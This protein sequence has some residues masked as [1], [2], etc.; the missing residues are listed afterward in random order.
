MKSTSLKQRKISLTDKEYMSLCDE[1]KSFNMSF[2]NYSRMILTCRKDRTEIPI[3]KQLASLLPEHINMVNE[4]ITDE[5]T[6][7]KFLQWEEKLWQ[8]I[9]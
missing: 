5:T 1:A 8:A 6:K 3:S 4:L 9:K 2:S 7:K